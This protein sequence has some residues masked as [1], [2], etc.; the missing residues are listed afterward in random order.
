MLVAEDPD[1]PEPDR[2]LRPCPGVWETARG[3]SGGPAWWRPADALAPEH[4]V[5]PDALRARLELL[6]EALAAGAAHTI[7]VRGPATTGRRTVLRVL[8]HRLAL[9]AADVDPEVLA[10]ERRLSV[11]VLAAMSDSLPICGLDPA[12]GETIRLPALPAY[13]GPARHRDARARRDR[14]AARRAAR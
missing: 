6:A 11:G 14:R 2:T 8:A 7:V 13:A 4:L 3:G 12:P 9:R 1:A 10:D 5:A